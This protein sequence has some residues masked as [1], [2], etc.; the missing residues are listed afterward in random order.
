[1]TN[2]LAVL[3][4]PLFRRVANEEADGLKGFDPGNVFALIEQTARTINSLQH[5][6]ERIGAREE[7]SRTQFERDRAQWR[8]D[9]TKMRDVAEACLER[10]NHAETEI[11]EAKA[12]TH[13]A[14]M[15]CREAHEREQSATARADEAE[16]RA[17]VAEQWLEKI[18]R[19]LSTDFKML[20]R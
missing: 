16:R 8:H 13:V 4:A 15:M 2:N 10:A 20:L 19:A 1:M 18:S 7:A 11:E 12:Q 6:N 17:E 14:L 5:E 9:L 3:A